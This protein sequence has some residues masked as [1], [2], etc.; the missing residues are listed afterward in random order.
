M[1]G[2]IARVTWKRISRG[3]AMWVA[4]GIALIPVIVATVLRQAV[5]DPTD[6]LT[7]TM[8]LY[9][10]EMFVMA[11]VPALFVAASIGEEIEDR[12]IT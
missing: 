4:L 1:I 7:F 11:I 5:T 8:D 2:T 6:R 3:Q 9:V 10:V 12:T